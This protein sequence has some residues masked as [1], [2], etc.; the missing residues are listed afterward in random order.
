MLPFIATNL[1]VWWGN[2]PGTKTNADIDIV[3]DNK[4][5]KK[6]LFG[7]CKWR[8]EP[9]DVPDVQKLKS[10][11]RLVPGYDEYRFMFFSKAPFTLAAERMEK[12]SDDLELITLDMMF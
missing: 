11:T 3:A 9:T 12:E 2:D 5:K 6:V 8:N 4:Q 1:G 7:E 10:K